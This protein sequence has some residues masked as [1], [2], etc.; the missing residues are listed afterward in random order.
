MLLLHF[1]RIFFILSWCNHT[2]AVYWTDFC[3]ITERNYLRGQW[4]GSDC[5]EPTGKGFD[6]L[7]SQRT[8]ERSG[9]FEWKQSSVLRQSYSTS[10]HSFSCSAVSKTCWFWPWPPEASHWVDP[11]SGGLDHTFLV[12]QLHLL[13]AAGWARCC[14]RPAN[15]GTRNYCLKVDYAVYSWTATDDCFTLTTP[16]TSPSQEK[17]LNWSRSE[18]EM[19]CS[20]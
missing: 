9:F 12:P 6:M 16:F 2:W 14:R 7:S 15:A 4:K 5:S 8:T 3:L 19:S 10:P 18:L 11:T 1:V 20:S 17:H 13:P